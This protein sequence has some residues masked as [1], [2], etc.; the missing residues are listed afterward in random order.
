MRRGGCCASQS[1]TPTKCA[2]RR[3][4]AAVLE[5]CTNMERYH[6][7]GHLSGSLGEL[8]RFGLRV[9]PQGV[10]GSS[11]APPRVTTWPSAQRLGRQRRALWVTVALLPARGGQPCAAPS[12]RVVERVVE[13]GAPSSTL[14]PARRPARARRRARCAAG[15]ADAPR[16]TVEGDGA[17]A[18]EEAEHEQQPEPAVHGPAQLS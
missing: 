10:T 4:D 2:G 11:I 1:P 3:G 12:S 8:A 7:H 17:G 13:R 18:A 15:A 6:R 9:V 16:D 5:P 14:P